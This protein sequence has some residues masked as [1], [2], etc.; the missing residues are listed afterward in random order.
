MNKRRLVI[1]NW[2]MYVE[3]PEDAKRFIASLKRRSRLFSGVDVVVAPSYPLITPVAA[4]L[5]SSQI[6]VGAQTVSA[7]EEAPRTGEVSAAILK[8]CGV[9]YA[10]VGHSERRA[11]GENDELV[12]AK[13]ERAVNAGLTAVLCVGEVERDPAGGHFTFIASQ[14]ASAL[15]NFPKVHAKRLVV[16]YEPVW[17]IGKSAA[18][19]MKGTELR[20]MS[21]FIKKTLTDALEREAAM[22]VP[23]LYGGSVEPDNARSLIAEGDVSGFLVG[24][25]SAQVETFVEILKACRN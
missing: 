3:R 10:I 7:H 12:A 11:M 22:R 4:A 2:K 5:K 1:A 15:K 6:K 14:I 13:L 8:A 18:D 9:T 23:I 17:A 19:A 20:E 21:I 16:A 25:A 24:H